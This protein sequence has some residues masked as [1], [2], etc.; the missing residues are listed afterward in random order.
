MATTEFAGLRFDPESALLAAAQ[1]DA[2]A[3]RLAG[4]VRDEQPK[5]TLVSAGSDEVSVRATQ[6]L[7]AV[8]ASFQQS[9]D[10]GVSELRRLATALRAQTTNF[11]QVES[12]SALG[13]AV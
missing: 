13:F 3:D 6:T 2:L 10:N 7:N 11:G 9:A 12:Q 5:L 4:G 1:L 8:A